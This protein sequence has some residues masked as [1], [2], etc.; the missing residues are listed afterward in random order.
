MTINTRN[1]VIIHSSIPSQLERIQKKLKQFKND[2]NGYL[3]ALTETLEA[4]VRSKFQTKKRINDSDNGILV[5][6]PFD[7][8]IVKFL[9]KSERIMEVIEVVLYKEVIKEIKEKFQDDWFWFSVADFWSLCR[10]LQLR[11][12]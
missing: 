8:T 1:I 12:Y 6:I 5:E 3:A 2:G 10:F 7:E 11:V 9:W 4:D